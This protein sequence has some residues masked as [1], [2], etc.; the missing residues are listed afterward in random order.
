[1]KEEGVDYEE[2]EEKMEVKLPKRELVKLVMRKVKMM[3]MMIVREIMRKTRRNHFTPTWL[4]QGVAV[5]GF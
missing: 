5:E 3:I 4:P 1:M 2:K